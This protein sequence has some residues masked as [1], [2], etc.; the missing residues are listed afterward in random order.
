L[1]LV[2]WVTVVCLL[3]LTCLFTW[4]SLYCNLAR[5]DMDESA[6]TARLIKERQK[7]DR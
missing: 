2:Y 6:E 1:T 4:A 7:R 5:R 3:A